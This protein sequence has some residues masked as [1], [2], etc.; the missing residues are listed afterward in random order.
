V[1]IAVKP[2][3]PLSSGEPRR[4]IITFQDLPKVKT[5]PKRSAT[6]TNAKV[7]E[8]E[9]ALQFT[10]ETLRSTIE[11]LETANE[12]L[13]STNEEYQSTNEELQSTNEELETSREELQS[14][15]EELSTV[16]TEHQLKIEELSTVNDDM[17]NL[18]NSTGVAILYLDGDLKVKRF[19]PSA[20]E[21]F[22]LIASDVNRPIHH[23]TSQLGDFDI[24]GKARKVLDTLIPVKETIETKAGTW[25][26]MRILPYRTI[27]N[28]IAGVVIS[29]VDISEQE[30]LKVSLSYAEA[31]IDTLFEPMVVLDADL[32]VITANKA[33]QETFKV[34]K[35]DAEGK[36]MF[37]LGEGG[38]NIPELKKTLKGVLDQSP[39]VRNYT[40]EADFRRVGRR[41]LCLNAR[42]LHDKE[43]DLKRVLLAIEDV[44]APRKTEGCL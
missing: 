32:R 5:E 43:S 23:I 21:I 30:R 31:V 25:Y 36:L 37:D 8:L 29:L 2:I 18:L 11:E 38:W 4:F 22:N 26:S 6:A 44:T 12:E 13:R 9:Q 17:K 24:S 34:S 39:E 20:T 41:R 35:P 16:N 27:D 7:A 3:P 14:V 1:R 15:N 28:A 40:I 10:K 33:F 19:T 42:Q